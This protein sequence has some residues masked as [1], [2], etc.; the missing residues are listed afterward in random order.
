MYKFV[1]MALPFP[2]ICR[3]KR[4]QPVLLFA[5][6]RTNFLISGPEFPS[7]CTEGAFPPPPYDRLLA[8]NDKDDKKTVF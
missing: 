7:C 1:K 8:E 4:N 5:V 6:T 3:G 2:I